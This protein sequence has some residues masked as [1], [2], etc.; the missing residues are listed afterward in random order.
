MGR[1]VFEMTSSF[2]QPNKRNRPNKPNND[3]II[4]PV[5]CCSFL[6]CARFGE[7][8]IGRRFF[9]QIRFVGAEHRHLDLFIREGQSKM[10]S[11]MSIDLLSQA[12][13]LSA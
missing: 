9:L 6:A 4:L 10:G 11:G 8:L 3:P 13:T 12:M 2:T 5:A 7:K 1:K